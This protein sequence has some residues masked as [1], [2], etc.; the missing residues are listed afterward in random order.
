MVVI[1]FQQEITARVGGVESV[2][3]G[4][5]CCRW[6]S[7][8]TCSIHMP[9][10]FRRSYGLVSGALSENHLLRLLS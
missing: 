4:I 5:I 2:G 7:N 8:A 1:G 9:Y 3:L 6:S 10:K